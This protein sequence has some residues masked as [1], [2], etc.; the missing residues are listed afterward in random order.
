MADNSKRERIIQADF[1]IVQ[2][3]SSI[4]TPIRTIPKYKDLQSYALPQLPVAAIV[5][6]L[7][8]P[9]EKKSGRTSHGVDQITSRLI[10]NVYVYLQANVDADAAISSL[11]DDLWR[12]LYTDP[13][14]GKLVLDT[15]LD[16]Q[17]DIQSWAPYLAFR[18]ICTHHY[19][20]DTGGI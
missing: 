11:V 19:I 10:V 20:H 14:R 12:E 9:V 13:S 2:G 18:L 1:S 5:G 15:T 8:K 6:G 17:E 4:K 3:I 16:L 7:P